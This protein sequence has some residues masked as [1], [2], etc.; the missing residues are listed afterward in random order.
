MGLHIL[1]TI[2]FK[3]KAESSQEGSCKWRKG[4]VVANF[5]SFYVVNTEHF[6]TTLLKADI[7]TGAVEFK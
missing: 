1:Q 5:P 6:T 4:I 7:K 2:V 3:D